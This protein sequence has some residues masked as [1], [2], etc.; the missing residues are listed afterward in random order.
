MV[1]VHGTCIDVAGVAVLLRGP[2]GSGKSDLALRLIDQGARLIADDQVE[3]ERADEAL[4]ACAP[5]PIAGM[6][7]VRGV[8]LVAGPWQPRGRLGLV[9]DL[10]PPEQVERLPETSTTSCQGVDLARVALTPF[11]A[12]ACA[13]VRLAARATRA[14]VVLNQ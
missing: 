2:A 8:G 4:V 5:Q 11:E 14:K 10:V 6:M 12:S 1:L 7:E 13:K 3:V 9:V